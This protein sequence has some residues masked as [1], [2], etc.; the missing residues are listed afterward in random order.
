MLWMARLAFVS[1]VTSILAV[2][3]CDQ[4]VEAIGVNDSVS[5]VTRPV[6]GVGSFTA[7]TAGVG[8]SGFKSKVRSLRRR[9]TGVLKALTKRAGK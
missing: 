2:K 5:R 4:I 8:M 1:V 3:V 9:H 7:A 6:V